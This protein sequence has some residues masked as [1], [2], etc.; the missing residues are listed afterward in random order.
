MTAKDDGVTGRRAKARIQAKKQKERREQI[1][2]W[3]FEGLW[4]VL[5][6]WFVWPIS[7]VWALVLGGLVIAIHFATSSMRVGSRVFF[8]SLLTVFMLIAI[9]FL[10]PDETSTHGFLTPGDDPSPRGPC[11]E[12]RYPLS[13]FVY[14]GGNEIVIDPN[15]ETGILVVGGH[16]IPSFLSTER[17]LRISGDIYSESGLLAHITNNEFTINPNTTFRT[18]RPDRHTLII[19]DNAGRENLRIR[20][21]NKRAIKVT[22]RLFFPGMNPILVTDTALFENGATLSGNCSSKINGAIRLP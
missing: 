8:C 20:F 14:F 19:R 16:E 4:F 5:D 11:D 6:L 2:S 3:L 21:L 12:S 7:H 22:G 13:D 18:E 1:R 10:P 15:V 17:G 9:Y